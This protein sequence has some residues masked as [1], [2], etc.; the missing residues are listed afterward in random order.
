MLDDYIPSA[1]KPGRNTR[2][3]LIRMPRRHE[4]YRT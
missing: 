1:A 3:R 4:L 2:Q